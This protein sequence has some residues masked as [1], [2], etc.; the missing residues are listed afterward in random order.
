VVEHGAVVVAGVDG[1]ELSHGA[2]VTGA[3]CVSG[4]AAVGS[5]NSHLRPV[6]PA[7]HLQKK[8]PFASE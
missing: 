2:C 6:V 8:F 5:T 3:G 4:G 1:A 7:L